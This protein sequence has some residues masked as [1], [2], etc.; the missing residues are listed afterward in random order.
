MQPFKL[1]VMIAIKKKSSH[2]KW[3]LYT[4]PCP[5]SASPYLFGAVD[6]KSDLLCMLGNLKSTQNKKLFFLLHYFYQLDFSNFSKRYCPSH[7]QA[8]QVLFAQR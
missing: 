1:H 8:I 7:I 5:S 2:L 4:V 3:S 6:H